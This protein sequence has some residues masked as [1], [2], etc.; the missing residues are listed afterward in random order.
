MKF[1]SIDLLDGV[2][3]EA[4]A[5]EFIRLIRTGRISFHILRSLGARG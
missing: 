3:D 1:M 2:V 4:E 5:F